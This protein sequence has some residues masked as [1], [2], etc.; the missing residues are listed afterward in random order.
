MDEDFEMAAPIFLFSE[1]VAGFLT[2]G[3]V[4][5]LLHGKEESSRPLRTHVIL[6]SVTMIQKST[7]PDFSV[8]NVYCIKLWK[9]FG[10]CKKRTETI[11]SFGRSNVIMT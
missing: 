11:K 6:T 2:R 4:S 8:E 9:R 3:E 1:E 5:Y 7:N 10:W